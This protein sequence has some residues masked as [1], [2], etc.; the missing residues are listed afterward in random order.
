MHRP[1]SAARQLSCPQLGVVRQFPQSPGA[2]RIQSAPRALKQILQKNSGAKACVENFAVL[3][4]LVMRCLLSSQP[5][6][7]LPFILGRSLSSCPSLNSMFSSLAGAWIDPWLNIQ[8][9]SL[10]SSHAV[11][12][13]FLFIST[14]CFLF[15]SELSQSLPVSLCLLAL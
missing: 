2:R 10:C 12:L 3:I 8:A 9:R 13:H 6:L 14:E 15:T 4:T 11:D 1:A 5:M 7:A